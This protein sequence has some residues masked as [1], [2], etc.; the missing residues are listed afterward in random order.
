M[1][2]PIDPKDTPS[3]TPSQH[4]SKAR[5]GLEP[6]PQEA[7]RSASSPSE[8]EP[9]ADESSQGQIGQIWT[10]FEDSQPQQLR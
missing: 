10:P 7:E 8:S 9:S 4:F 6:D 2:E 1:V 5:R 3:E